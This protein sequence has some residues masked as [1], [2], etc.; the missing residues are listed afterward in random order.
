MKLRIRGNSVRLR[1]GQSEVR[2]LAEIGVVEESTQFDD[3]GDQSLLYAVKSADGIAGASAGFQGGK[4]LVLL[5]RDVVARWA[6]SD[7]VAIAAVQSIGEN[8]SLKI[9]VEKDFECIEAPADEPQ[10]DAFRRPQDNPV[11]CALGSGT[12]HGAN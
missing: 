3:S 9:L 12:V 7:E 11:T 6:S 10:D 1:L 4:L 2:R 8:A 5:P